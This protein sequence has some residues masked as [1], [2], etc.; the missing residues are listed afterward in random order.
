MPRK[1]K[2]MAVPKDFGTPNT[3]M[4]LTFKE[5]RAMLIYAKIERALLP[6]AMETPYPGKPSNKEIKRVAALN[7]ELIVK[8]E[9]ARDSF[10]YI[11][12]E[13]DAEFT[14]E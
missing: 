7:E 12:G 13:I 6:L 11:P 1:T 2:R 10:N 8:L 4:M 5:V 14:E 3:I 9:A